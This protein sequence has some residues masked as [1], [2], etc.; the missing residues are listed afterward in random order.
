VAAFCY[1]DGAELR[2]RQD[3]SYH[4]LGQ[5]FVFPSG[6]RCRTFDDFAEGCREEWPAARDLLRQG[7]FQQF[8]GGMGRTD[9]AKAAH[10]ALSQQDADI[11]LTRF[12]DA[13]PQT[14]S[15]APKIDINPRRL[16]L[17]N[18]LAGEQRQLQLIVTNQGQ[19]SLQGTMTV[20]EGGDWLKI[21]GVNAAQCAIATKREQH[22]VLR[23]D[24]R[25]LP[26]GGTFGAKLRVITNG[27]VAE[28]LARMELVAQPFMKAPFQ[29]AKTPRDMAERM[30]KLPKAAVP[31]LENGE[32]SR[33]FTSNGW[34]FPIRGPQ[35]KGVAGIQ[36]FFETMGLS[37]PPAVQVS[38]EQV[39]LTC[40]YPETVRSQVVLETAA[41]K[42]V[43]ASV[44]SDNPWLRVLTPQ[45]GGPQQATIAFEVD[46]QVGAGTPLEGKLEIAA[47]GG[48]VVRIPVSVEVRGA[49][50]GRRDMGRLEPAVVPA[51]PILVASTAP[52]VTQEARRGDGRRQ[53]A[54]SSASVSGGSALASG[55]LTN[56]G[57]TRPV[58][59]MALAFLLV[60][61]LLVP[62]VDFGGQ[63]GAVAA[64]A[65]KLGVPPSGDNVLSTAGG[66]L[67]L[68]WGRILVG[69]EGSLPTKWFDPAQTGEI[70]L[71]EF[72][73]YFASYFFR[74]LAV[75]MLWIGALVGAI[76][77]W[78]LGGLANI[79]WGA[80]AGAVAGVAASVT[81]SSLF[82][83]LEVVPH[84]LWDLIAPGQGAGAY[85]L[86]V[87]CALACWAAAGALVGL[88]LS[89]ATPCRVH[90][91][92][93][94][95]RTMAGLCRLCGLRGLAQACGV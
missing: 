19:G 44:T 49:P 7:V 72:R 70:P 23:V 34:N 40:T 36:Q 32:I 89:V 69:A 73:H 18:L 48:N 41:K 35:A 8:F 21:E 10:D 37:K 58:L 62:L 31:L 68:P 4:R 67:Q 94:V 26:A 95:Q 81:V 20:A 56:G 76:M 59:A 2:S 50:R 60:R 28:V 71:R 65:A 88:V 9:L 75:S 24:T 63:S 51:V 45:V 30:R 38:P 53:V 79:L 47:N 83:V 77:L 29:G 12:L 55:G 82:L 64:A 43:Y 3:G 42:W 78:R 46:P 5:D 22:V 1:F 92:W 54:A 52:A 87:V 14:E 86:W 25:G 90:V 39:R 16:L 27:G 57:L 84:V 61:I 17:G 85:F 93:P 80:V 91:V 15:P 66:W 74:G 6:R 11:A 33:W 13:L